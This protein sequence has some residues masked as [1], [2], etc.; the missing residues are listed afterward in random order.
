MPTDFAV[1]FQ[2]KY[3]GLGE[4]WKRFAQGETPEALPPHWRSVNYYA[5]VF[6]NDVDPQVR[7]AAQTFLSELDAAKFDGRT[8][9]ARL[10][11]ATQAFAQAVCQYAGLEWE[12]VRRS[13][14]QRAASVQPPLTSP[15][16]ATKAPKRPV[17]SAKPAA[18]VRRASTS[19]VVAAKAPKRPAVPKARAGKK[20]STAK[21]PASRKLPASKRPV[22]KTAPKPAGRKKP[23]AK[24]TRSPKGRA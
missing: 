21:K 12:P 10:V 15:A 17:A 9:I 19:S 18:A 23:V 24:R 13:T 5:S 7:L 6:S 11:L 14:R 22:A 4:V 2:A 1:R 20:T 8:Y 3:A 16:V